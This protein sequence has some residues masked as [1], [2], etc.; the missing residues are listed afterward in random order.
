MERSPLF[1]LLFIL[2]IAA[3]F[4]GA[5]YY[6]DQLALTPL[7]L[8][9]FVPDC[10]L[11]VLLT[12]PLLARRIKNGTYSFLVA[13][14]MAKYGLWTVF[15]LLFHWDVYS[16]PGNL[17]VTIIFIVGHTG[18]ALL[19]AALIPAKRIALPAMLL[20]LAWFLLNDLSDYFWGTRP[21]IPSRDI[22]FVRNITIVA[23][24]ALTLSFYFYGEKIRSISP[25]KFFRW[26]IQN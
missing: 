3:V 16:L 7:L 25:V 11:Y 4:A 14:G 13:I 22:D 19:G 17:L 23:S 8:L 5:Y 1:N 9:I 10:P 20:I 2:C 21:P 24:L 12:L 26:V 18:M 15:V 6:Y